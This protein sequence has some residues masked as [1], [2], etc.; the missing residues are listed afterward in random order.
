MSRDAIKELSKSS[1]VA[2]PTSSAFDHLNGLRNERYVDVTNVKKRMRIYIFSN[3]LVRTI[4]LPT[5]VPANAIT[6][7]ADNGP[8]S[9]SRLMN[10]DTEITELVSGLKL[11]MGRSSMESSLIDPDLDDEKLLLEQPDDS[12]PLQSPNNEIDLLAHDFDPLAASQTIEA[13]PMP[14]IEKPVKNG[15][16]HVNKP[17]SEIFIDLN[18]I[19]PH[20]EYQPRCILDESSGLKI[21]LNF[22]KDH[23]RPDVVV[24]V[25]T[26]TNHNSSP[27]FN[28]Q[29]EASVTKVGHT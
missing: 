28:Y 11:N 29:F 15:L 25:I 2:S 7:I 8:K 5:L 10:F 26:T 19:R 18:S 13:K 14:N 21:M 4:P 27:L 22:T 17:L 9:T 3:L 20:D 1:A 16:E 12:A 6:S 24:L 23:P